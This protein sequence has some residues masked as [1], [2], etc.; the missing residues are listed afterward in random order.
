MEWKPSIPL[1]F[2]CSLLE[3]CKSLICLPLC[4]LVDAPLS[5]SFKHWISS[6]WDWL[7]KHPSH[8]LL[9]D[10][11]ACRPWFSLVLIKLSQSICYPLSPTPLGSCGAQL[12]SHPKLDFNV[13]PIPIETIINYIYASL[14]YIL[15]V[16][17]IL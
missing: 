12:E 13:L 15:W 8:A 17:K 7:G 9:T 5:H 1:V 2:S 16:S 3:R 10:M 14:Q 4:V 11:A 6:N